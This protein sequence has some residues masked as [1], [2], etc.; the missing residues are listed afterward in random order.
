[1]SITIF[2]CLNL[3]MTSRIL[4]A[5]FLLIVNLAM[6]QNGQEPC[7]MPTPIAKWSFNDLGT[8]LTDWTGNGYNGTCN[9]LTSTPGWRGVPN[10]A[11]LF[12]GVN[13]SHAIVNSAAALSPQKFTIVS[14]VKPTEMYSGTCQVT[15]IYSKGWPYFVTGSYQLYMQDNDASCTVS[16]PGTE[17]VGASIG[18]SSVPMPTGPSSIVTNDWYFIAASYDGAQLKCYQEIFTPT[19]YNS[20]VLP[21]SSRPETVSIGSNSS[22][23]YFGFHANPP[24]PYNFEGAMD[25]VILYGKALTA[26]EIQCVYDSLYAIPLAINNESKPSDVAPNYFQNNEGVTIDLNSSKSYNYKILDISGRVLATGAVN[27]INNKINT[28]NLPHQVLFIQLSNAD[29][30]HI[31][32]FAN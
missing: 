28:I 12:S 18:T 8:V 16:S 9:G 17:L 23:I 24:F 21:Y 2:F 22:P 26:S 32:K 6:G 15:S 5:A 4:T 7:V 3:F 19:S 31:I 1:M 10:A 25:E 30:T 20:S 13:T 27:E 11:K 29:K 14:L